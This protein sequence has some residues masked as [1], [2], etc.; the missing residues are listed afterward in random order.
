VTGNPPHRTQETVDELERAPDLSAR[1]AQYRRMIRKAPPPTDHHRI[2][3]VD[4]ML[5]TIIDRCLESDPRKRYPNVQA[6]LEAFTTRET[7]LARR[8]MMLLGALGPTLMLLIVTWF[9]WRGFGTI[10]HQSDRALTDRAFKTNRF[11]AQNIAQLTG[12]ELDRR[13]RAVRYMAE[14]TALRKVL[15]EE[16]GPQGT[17]RDLLIQLRDPDLPEERG[18]RLRREF[19]ASAARE[20]IQD[21]LAGRLATRSIPNTAGWSLFDA[22]GIYLARIPEPPGEVTMGRYYG[23]RS[24]FTGLPEDKPPTWQ[25]EPGRHLREAR[26]SGVYRSQ[27]TKRWIVTISAPIFDTSPARDFLG[28]IALMV[29]VGR[30]AEFREGE[31]QFA[32][33]VDWRDGPDKGVILQHPGLERL[34]LDAEHP[35]DEARLKRFRV[36]LAESPQHPGRLVGYKDPFSSQPPNQQRWIAQASPVLVEG[37]ETGLVVVVQESYQSAIGATLARLRTGL[38]RY[39]FL[40]LAFIAIVMIGVWVL[41]LRLFGDGIGAKAAIAPEDGSGQPPTGSPTPFTPDTPTETLGRREEGSMEKG[42]D[43]SV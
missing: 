31:Q 35:P 24:Y 17:L 6:V 39:G 9:A 40:A 37:R 7:R 23:W 14:S 22:R 41:A 33:L 10:I 21:V 2:P 32:T 36:K 38:I 1:L 8:P 27:A 19:A 25:V 11:V 42:G 26:M 29:E 4:H 30:F 5:A 20:R 3:G 34:L 28:V 18:A 43:E 15:L 13:F 12:T 16:T